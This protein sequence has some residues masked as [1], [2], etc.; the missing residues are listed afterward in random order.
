MATVIS[1]IFFFGGQEGFDRDRV[2]PFGEADHFRAHLVDVAVDR[3][4]EMV[5]FEKIAHAVERFVVDEN[6]TEQSLF[7]FH[8]LRCGTV[9]L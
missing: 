7:G 2:R 8:I 3:L 9:C 1:P 6:G 5:G 4:V